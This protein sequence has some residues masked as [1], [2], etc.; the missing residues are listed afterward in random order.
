M[1]DEVA[2]LVGIFP[3]PSNELALTIPFRSLI[4]VPAC[5]KLAVRRICSR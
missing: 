3:N 4:M 5:A 2:A 1:E